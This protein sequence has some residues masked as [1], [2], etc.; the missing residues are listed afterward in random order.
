MS[1]FML[2]CGILLIVLLI[3]LG[4]PVQDSPKVLSSYLQD[5]SAFSS[6]EEPASWGQY[7]VLAMRFSS[8]QTKTI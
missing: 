1:W 5:P 2:T 7:T 8:K 3:D 6:G 4:W